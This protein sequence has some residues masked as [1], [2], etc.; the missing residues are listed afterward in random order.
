MGLNSIKIGDYKDNTPIHPCEH[1]FSY[2]DSRE[3]DKKNVKKKLY[4]YYDTLYRLDVLLCTARGDDQSA[5]C[6]ISRC[7]FV[8]EMWECEG[9][10]ELLGLQTGAG[11]PKF[12]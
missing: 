3:Q 4:A 6:S 12:E 11:M 2:T 10:K 7:I 5:Q 8:I 9:K 1:G